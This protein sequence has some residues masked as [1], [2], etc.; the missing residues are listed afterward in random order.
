MDG[1]MYRM[2][3]SLACLHGF[4][5]IYLVDKGIVHHVNELLI[6]STVKRRLSVRLRD[7]ENS[8]ISIFFVLHLHIAE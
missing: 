2:S 6:K 5:I 1:W 4:S 7:E 3:V 8:F